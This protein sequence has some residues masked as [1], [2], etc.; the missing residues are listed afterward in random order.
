MGRIVN[1]S[2]ELIPYTVFSDLLLLFLLVSGALLNYLLVI[3]HAPQCAFESE[4]MEILPCFFE[5][6]NT[7][8][9]P[10]T[11]KTQRFSDSPELGSFVGVDL[12]A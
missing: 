2:A 1:P 3:H 10:I 8:A 4:C 9:Q 11:N 6:I 12:L 5:V 7:P